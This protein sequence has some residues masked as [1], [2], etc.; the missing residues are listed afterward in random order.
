MYLPRYEWVYALSFISDRKAHPVLGL[1]NF[2]SLGRLS[3]N[4]TNLKF[5]GFIC[6]KDL[7]D[8]LT[9]LK[10]IFC[11]KKPKVNS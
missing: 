5:V 1:C 8:R 11:H 2:W 9:F 10:Q 3:S 4:H 6:I 7:S